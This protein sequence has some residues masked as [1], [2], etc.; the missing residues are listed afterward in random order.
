M[1]H[2]PPTGLLLK[3]VDRETKVLSEWPDVHVIYDCQVFINHFLDLLTYVNYFS[4]IILMQCAYFFL[5]GSAPNWNCANHVF[6]LGRNSMYH[7]NNIMWRVIPHVLNEQGH[8]MYLWITDT[9][10]PRWSVR[11]REV[12][13]IRKVHP[14]IWWPFPVA[15]CHVIESWALLDYRETLNVVEWIEKAKIFNNFQLFYT[16]KSRL[17]AFRGKFVL[18]LSIGTWLQCP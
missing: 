3:G 1:L 7:K 16:S 2:C 12:F 6:T 11:N 18:I 5:T 9:T 13:F 10:G 17:S 4:L 15:I 14:V 8:A